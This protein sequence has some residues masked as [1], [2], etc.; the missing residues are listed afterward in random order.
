MDTAVTPGNAR[1]AEIEAK[2]LIRETDQFADVLASLARLG[3]EINEGPTET[4]TDRYFDTPDWRILRAGWAYRCRECNGRKKLMLKSLGSRDG[5]VFSREEVEQALPNEK[6]KKKGRLPSGPVQERVSQFASGKR[7]H[8]LFRVRS[9]RTVYDIGVPGG[10]GSRLELDFDRTHIK[11]KRKANK[12]APGQFRFMEI[13]FETDDVKTASTLAEI[14]RDRHGLIPSQFSKFERGIQAA[15]LE[16][17]TVEEARRDPPRPKQPILELIYYYLEQQL[18]ALKLQF[19]RAWEGL[20]PE[21]V[22][23]MRVAIRRARTVLKEFRKALPTEERGHLNAELRWLLKQLGQ[24]R[25]ADVCEAAIEHYRAG[26]HGDPVEILAPFETH[27]RRTTLGAQV[28]LVAA[29]SSDRYKALIDEYE[30]FLRARAAGDSEKHVQRS[31]AECEDRLVHLVVAKMQDK[32]RKITK[33]SPARK[34]HRLRLLAKRLRY[35]LEFFR[36]VRPRK[37]RK[38]IA[39]LSTMQD[40]LGE[41]QDAIVARQRLTTYAESIALLEENR[42]LLLAMGRLTQQEEDRA[43]LYRRKFPALWAAFEQSIEPLL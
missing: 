5:A 22:H 26:L 15:G 13:E 41:H 38:P 34:L 20:D 17:T 2:F 1:T 8:E 35:L 10:L 7:R 16:A 33:E 19:P 40:E 36:V 28:E 14:L 27:L 9:E 24:V 21:G 42:R 4:H 30:R 31:I 18:D 37:W 23:K 29:L 25:D 12:K 3:Y 32:A 39:A 6:A 43:I 11:A